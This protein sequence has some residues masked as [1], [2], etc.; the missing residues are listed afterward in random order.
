MLLSSSTLQQCKCIK[1]E[2]KRFVAENLSTS[3]VESKYEYEK[4]NE[5][6]NKYR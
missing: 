6:Q 3:D 4:E 5:S 2:G 1:K